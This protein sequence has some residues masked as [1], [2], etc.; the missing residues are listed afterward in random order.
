MEV[1]YSWYKN[2]KK[3]STSSEN[4]N[5][6]IIQGKEDDAGTYRVVAKSD[7]VSLEAECQV[8]ILSKRIMFYVIF[9]C[10][11]VFPNRIHTYV[12][13]YMHTCTYAHTRM[14]TCT[15]ALHCRARTHARARAHARMYAYMHI[16]E[17]LKHRLNSFP[18]RCSFLHS[19]STK[20]GDSHYCR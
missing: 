2:R 17:I 18:F 16:S 20:K 4:G 19:C 8:K 9:P 7:G 15:H 14:P 10:F 12:H 13:A 3:L 11:T 5:Y 1:T 6:R